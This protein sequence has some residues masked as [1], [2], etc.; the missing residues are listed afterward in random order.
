MPYGEVISGDLSGIPPRQELWVCLAG[1][2]SNAA[3]ALGFVALWWLYPETY[4]YTDVA[5]LVSFSLFLVNLLPAYPLDG[6]RIL[7]IALRR[8]GDKKA[9]ILLRTITLTAAACVFA[10]FVWSC[11]SEANF[12]ALLFSVL[13]AAG[14]FGGEEYKR[15]TF[16]RSKNFARGVE[17]RRIALS[18]DVTAGEAMRFLRE[19]K[20][21][22]LI[23]F[24]GN[25]FLGELTEEELL[26]ALEQGEY[27]KKTKELLAFS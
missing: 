6:G 19:D 1:P 4:P 5:A 7:R 25:E 12:G 17:E 8:F 27:G 13:L 10:F 26:C 15:L 16:S 9:R 23:L 18:G 22:V 20:Y 11:F 21:L 2:L 24:E 3:T 14:A